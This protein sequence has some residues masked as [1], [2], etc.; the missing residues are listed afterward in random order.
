MEAPLDKRRLLVSERTLGSG[1]ASAAEG[2]IAPPLLSA[3]NA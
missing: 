2:A 3:G 1:T